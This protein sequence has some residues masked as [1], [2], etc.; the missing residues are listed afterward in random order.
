MLDFRCVPFLEEGFIIQVNERI[1]INAN[2]SIAQMVPLVLVALMGQRDMEY[3]MKR[4]VADTFNIS[5]E[6]WTEICSL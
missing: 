6:L 3:N 4:W 1:I 5:L 2:L